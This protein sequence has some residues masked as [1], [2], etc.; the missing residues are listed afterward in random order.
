MLDLVRKALPKSG[1]M[2]VFGDTG[3]EFPDTYEIVRKVEQQCKEEGIAFYR[4]ASHMEP[5]QSWRIFGPPSRALRW[6]CTVHKSAPQTIKIRE[7]LGKSDYIGADFV[8][9]RS[10][11]SA[12]RSEYDYENVGKKQKGQ[13]SQNPILDWSSAEIWL[14]IYINKLLINETYKKGNSGQ[15]VCF[16]RWEAEK[17]IFF[18]IR[19]IPQK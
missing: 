2:V 3:M 9:V 16:A 10:Y 13:H 4:A 12:T 6:C 14:Y 8:G 11:E 15:G 19:P 1:F 17:E 18:N 7:V 5:M